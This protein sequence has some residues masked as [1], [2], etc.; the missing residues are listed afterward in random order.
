MCYVYLRLG[1]AV[2]WKK[3]LEY[4]INW[5]DDDKIM[6][7]TLGSEANKIE[8]SLDATQYSSAKEMR[9]SSDNRKINLLTKIFL[10]ALQS[11]FKKFD[12]LYNQLLDYSIDRW[13]IQNTEYSRVKTI[14]LLQQLWKHSIQSNLNSKVL[15]QSDSL[16][17]N[18]ISLM[19]NVFAVWILLHSKYFLK[20][21]YYSNKSNPFDPNHGIDK[22]YSKRRRIPQFVA[23]IRLLSMDDKQKQFI[24]NLVQIGTGE[25]KSLILALL[26]FELDCACCG[27]LLTK[28]D[29]KSFEKSFRAL[30]VDN[31]IEYGTCVV[32]V[33][34]LYDNSFDGNRYALDTLIAETSNYVLS[35]NLIMYLRK[36]ARKRYKIDNRHVNNSKSKDGQKKSQQKSMVRRVRPKIL[37]IDEV[38]VMFGRNTCG[39]FIWRDHNKFAN[40]IIDNKNGGYREY[41]E[42]F[43]VFGPSWIEL[44]DRE[45]NNM[46][47]DVKYVVFEGKIGY[48][49]ADFI[50][51]NTPNGYRTLF[52]YYYEYEQGNIADISLRIAKQINL[53][54]EIPNKFSKIM[55]VTAALQYQMNNK[56]YHIKN[57]QYLNIH[58]CHQYLPTILFILMKN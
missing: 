20:N 24:P 37:L 54:Y 57:V 36:Q 56:Q 48:K 19:A 47:V 58:I 3:F 46:I 6:N 52:A 4:L 18:M 44:M 13:N 21:L 25:G 50:D 11:Q 12:T 45:I 22:N 43:R 33:W 29:Y 2:K 7:P 55:G 14:S 5:D 30:N 39:D 40:G 16:R 32:L 15:I 26:G 9:S 10:G 38:D 49:R 35:Q 8:L 34:K 53:R 41:E 28:R 42:C 51:T 17:N 31:L 27:Q 1:S 23:V